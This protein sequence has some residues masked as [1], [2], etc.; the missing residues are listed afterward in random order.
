MNH[1]VSLARVFD[2]LRRRRRAT[3]SQLPKPRAA[4]FFFRARTFLSGWDIFEVTCNG[5]FDDA[6]RSNAGANARETRRCKSNPFIT[7]ND[8]SSVARNVRCAPRG[9]AQIKW[10]ILRHVIG[11]PTVGS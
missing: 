6:R 5:N 2:A 7:S 3:R 8:A 4:L 1:I 9:V 11:E 10:D